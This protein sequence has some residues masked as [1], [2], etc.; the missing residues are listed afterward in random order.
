[1]EGA[2]LAGEPGTTTEASLVIGLEPNL[3][4]VILDDDDPDFDLS[5]LND[6][7]ESLEGYEL[8]AYASFNQIDMKTGTFSRVLR[9]FIG[10]D[11]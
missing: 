9:S 2:Y 3:K 8:Y 11:S 5:K 6:Y 7:W 10:S 4:D 1:M